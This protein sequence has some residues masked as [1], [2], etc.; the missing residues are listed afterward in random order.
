MKRVEKG[1]EI[2]GKMRESDWINSFDASRTTKFPILHSFF[3][4]LLSVPFPVIS[5]VR[6]VNL[7]CKLQ[8]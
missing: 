4:A 5:I 3:A 7:S 2:R 6:G 1:E 8:V